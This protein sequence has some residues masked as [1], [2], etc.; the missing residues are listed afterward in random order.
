MEITGRGIDDKD[1]ADVEIRVDYTACLIV[2]L[3]CIDVKVR[4]G[5]ASLTFVRSIDISICDSKETFWKVRRNVANH[6]LH[7]YVV[8]SCIEHCQ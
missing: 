6:V 4:C 2:K 5:K 3:R 1:K 7:A 8:Y